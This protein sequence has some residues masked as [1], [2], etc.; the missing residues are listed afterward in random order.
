MS[1]IASLLEK[2]ELGF[3]DLVALLSVD[4]PDDVQRILD[5]GQEVKKKTVGNKV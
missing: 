5:K 2:P 1:A 3:D 4:D